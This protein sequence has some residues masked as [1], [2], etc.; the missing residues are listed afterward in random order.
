[1]EP[2]ERHDR[3]K[4]LAHAA[5]A[6]EPAGEAVD[7]CEHRGAIHPAPDARVLLLLLAQG[8]PQYQEQEPLPGMDGWRGGGLPPLGGG[9][10]RSQI[11]RASWRGR[12]EISVG[13]V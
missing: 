8:I 12:E 4:L 13:A 3:E 6:Q 7:F 10:Y 11:G 2:A 5:A 1:M 9:E